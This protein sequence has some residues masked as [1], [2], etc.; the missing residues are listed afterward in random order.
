MQNRAKFLTYKEVDNKFNP[1]CLIYTDNGVKQV[2]SNIATNYLDYKE[3]DD[4]IVDYKNIDEFTIVESYSIK[5]IT[6]KILFVLALILVLWLF[7]CLFGIQNM[8][9]PAVI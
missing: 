6:F 7:V 1:R 2:T 3:G 8:P 5:Q 9:K 4:L